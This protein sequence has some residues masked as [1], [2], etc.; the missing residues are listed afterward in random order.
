MIEKAYTHATGLQKVHFVEEFYGNEFAL[1]KAT[2]SRKLADILEEQ[3][4]KR[5][6]ILKNIM[7]VVNTL[8]TKG[9]IYLSISHHVLNE[10]YEN[11]TPELIR[12]MTGLLAPELVHTVRTRYGAQVAAKCAGYASAKERKAIIKSL[13]GN[14]LP[15]AQEPHGHMLIV[16]LLA[17]TDD[18]VLLTKAILRELLD[19]AEELVNDGN[20]R[21]P[22]LLILAPEQNLTR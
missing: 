5:E 7:E 14:I 3:P 21:L 20:G 13:K 15:I 19:G 9:L 2:Q 11:G 17:V 6:Q 16:K 12:E 10:F 4:E 8:L 22:F 1:F 18:T